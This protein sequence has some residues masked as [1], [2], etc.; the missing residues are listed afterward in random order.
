MSVIENSTAEKTKRV[1]QRQTGWD[2]VKAAALG[3]Q[4]AW[5]AGTM[6]SD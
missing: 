2:A 6:G 4:V 1:G 5:R 3:S